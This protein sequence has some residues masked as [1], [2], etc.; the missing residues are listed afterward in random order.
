MRAPGL[1]FGVELGSLV[2]LGDA[3]GLE[4]AVGNVL[5][6]AVKWSLPG[7]T[8]HVHLTGHQLR[9]GD[10]G[11]GIAA[12]A[13]PHVF[14]RFYRADSAR[15]TPGTGLGLAVA[16][17]VVHDH[18]GTIRAE[19]PPQGGA[20]FVIELPGTFDADGSASDVQAASRPLAAAVTG[21]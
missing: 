4:Q 15:S 2:V 16:A 18:G 17:K 19:S 20:L 9:I 12:A 3:A 7:G 5:D 13:L 10:E 1:V 8:I 6:N 14:D 11:P 21:G